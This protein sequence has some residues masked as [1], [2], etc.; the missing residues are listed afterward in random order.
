MGRLRRYIP[1][2]A[3]MMAI[4][5]LALTGFP[6]TAGYYSK[7]AIIEAAYV[8]HRPGANFAFFATVLAAFMTSFYSWR[9]FFLTFEGMK[10]WG[11]HGEHHVHGDHEGV[12]HD[13]RSHD[14]EPA[15]HADHEHGHGHGAHTPHE[16]PLVMLI[17]LIL[18]AIGALV[19]GFAFNNVFIGDGY[20]GFWKGALF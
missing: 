9:L 20:A 6:F 16:S 1:F 4:G 12:E 5:T 2:T 11:A 15:S 10:R 7:D 8:S 14:V 18:L 3:A 13:E 19:A 17:P